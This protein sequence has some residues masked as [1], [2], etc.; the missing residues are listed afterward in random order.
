MR[1][2][3]ERGESNISEGGSELRKF[4]AQADPAPLMDDAQNLAVSSPEGEL[5]D[6]D[7]LC[8][9]GPRLDASPIGT[10]V[11]AP[12]TP[13]AP[14]LL[15]APVFELGDCPYF[16]PC[17]LTIPGRCGGSRACVA[18]DAPPPE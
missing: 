1:K 7:V 4:I 12:G 2:L 3:P 15:H 16:M 11:A 13:L 10:P 9:D 8:A 5:S 6:V 17:S 18:R 14:H